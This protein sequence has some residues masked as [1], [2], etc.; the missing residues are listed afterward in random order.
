MPFEAGRPKTGGRQAGVVN[1]KTQMREALEDLGVD[2]LKALI[3]LIPQLEPDEQ[4]QHFKDLLAYLYPKRKAIELSQDP[5]SP[6][7]TTQAA[8]VDQMIE[9]VKAAKQIK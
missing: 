4:A 7:L 8:P 3:D 1:K 5:D 2:P 9:L 6:A